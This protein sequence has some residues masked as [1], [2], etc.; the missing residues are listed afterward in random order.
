ML[1]TTNYKSGACNGQKT[2]LKDLLRAGTQ[3]RAS[4]P[5]SQFANFHAKTMVFDSSV[6]LT[7][8]ANLTQNAMTNTKEHVSRF[9]D[10]T[11]ID[12]SSEWEASSGVGLE[13]LPGQK[14]ENPTAAADDVRQRAASANVEAPCNTTHSTAAREASTV[15][16]QQTS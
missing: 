14:I 4:R 5:K 11:F 12:F 10:R 16:H 2:R 3:I 6:A 8:S 9:T 7:C 15:E 13:D 1:D